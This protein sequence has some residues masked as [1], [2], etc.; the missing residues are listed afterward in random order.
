MSVTPGT[1]VGAD[2]QDTEA[3]QQRWRG[4]PRA[5]GT[6]PVHTSVSEMVEKEEHHSILYGGVRMHERDAD[7]REDSWKGFPSRARLSSA[8]SLRC[9][10]IH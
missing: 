10:S 8:C 3:P 1:G 4:F 6:Q 5:T 7:S 2:A 9:Q